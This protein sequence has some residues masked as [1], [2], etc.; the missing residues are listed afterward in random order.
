MQGSLKSWS[1]KALSSS[2]VSLV[3][4]RLLSERRR[5]LQAHMETERRFIQ[6]LEPD[7]LLHWFSNGKS[8]YICCVANFATAL[9]PGVWLVSTLAFCY[10]TLSFYISTLTDLCL[11]FRLSSSWAT[12]EHVSASL[13]ISLRRRNRAFSGYF[14]SSASSSKTLSSIRSVRQINGK[15]YYEMAEKT[16]YLHILQ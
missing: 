9:L 10:I 8:T 15:K 16:N 2:T 3:R 4:L 7:Q 12:E 5:L 14:L 6:T 13:T 11:C 1:T